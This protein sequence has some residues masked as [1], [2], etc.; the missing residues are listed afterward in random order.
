MLFNNDQKSPLKK[1]SIQSIEN[2]IKVGE[3]IIVSKCEFTNESL[4]NSPIYNSKLEA[5]FYK[6]MDLLKCIISVKKWN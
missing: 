1:S 5:E 3:G 6:N 4:K 2:Q